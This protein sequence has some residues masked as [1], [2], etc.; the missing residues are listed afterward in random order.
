[1]SVPICWFWNVGLVI[2]IYNYEKF[3]NRGGKGEE[4]NE[5]KVRRKRRRVRRWRQRTGEEGEGG[6][7]RGGE[8]GVGE[9][10]GR[11]GGEK[12]GV[13]G[14]GRWVDGEGGG[15]GEGWPFRKFW[16]GSLIKLIPNFKKNIIKIQDKEI[17]DP[18]VEMYTYFFKRKI[19][20]IQSFHRMVKI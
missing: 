4:E 3:S 8:G 15:G 16:I 6:V 1:M 18:I 19:Y 12:G 11:G 2:H 14:R 5:E 10:E 9:R 17:I 20:L 13:Q 7:G